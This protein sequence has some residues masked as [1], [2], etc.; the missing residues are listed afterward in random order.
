ME[1]ETAYISHYPQLQ[2]LTGVSSNSTARAA[3]GQTQW[4][5]D[6]VDSTQSVL[7]SF[8]GSQRFSTGSS[9]HNSW[10]GGQDGYDSY[11]ER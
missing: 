9:D 8:D 11:Q 7:T 5:S 3:S 1:N 2:D 4:S 10:Y 6:G